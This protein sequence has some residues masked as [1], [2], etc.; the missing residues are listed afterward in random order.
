M[1]RAFQYT[2]FIGKSA[3]EDWNSLVTKE[4][5]DRSQRA[6]VEIAKFRLPCFPV[7]SVV[8]CFES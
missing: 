5:V 6:G 3:R 4:A 1:G 7:Y 2:L 8:L